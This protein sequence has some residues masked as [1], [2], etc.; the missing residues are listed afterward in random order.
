MPKRHR[1]AIA[2]PDP[3]EF[4][5]FMDSLVCEIAVLRNIVIAMV[6]MTNLG[7]PAEARFLKMLRAA[8][9]AGLDRSFPSGDTPSPGQID[10]RA[11]AFG[12]L[13]ALLREAGYEHGPGGHA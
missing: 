4:G 8:V 7:A 2:R 1:K 5:R 9:M 12:R 13:E 10:I 11:R 3:A 6:A